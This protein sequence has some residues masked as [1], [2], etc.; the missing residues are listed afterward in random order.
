MCNNRLFMSFQACLSTTAGNLGVL[1]RLQSTQHSRAGPG[2]PARWQQ[3][4]PGM[5]LPWSSSWRTHFCYL[6]DSGASGSHNS[7]LHSCTFLT[8]ENWHAADF[9]FPWFSWRS[10]EGH[11]GTHP[12]GGSGLQLCPWLCGHLVQLLAP[13]LGCWEVFL[14]GKRWKLWSNDL[15]PQ[16]NFSLQSL[17]C[18]SHLS[19]LS[20]S[21]CLKLRKSQSGVTRIFLP[22]TLTWSSL[23]FPQLSVPLQ[24]QRHSLGKGIPSLKSHHQKCCCKWRREERKKE[25]GRTPLC[26]PWELAP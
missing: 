17:S 25:T 12:P 2:S 8:G 26:F 24:S 3:G 21:L 20:V 7:S 15:S 22:S 5:V 1:G 16:S 13:F 6:I 10:C 9:L 23:L 4:L 18:L 19:E 14:Q 11:W